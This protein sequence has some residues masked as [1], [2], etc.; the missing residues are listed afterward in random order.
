MKTLLFPS[1]IAALFSMTALLGAEIPD[2]S[3][4]TITPPVDSSK[5]PEGLSDSDWSTIRAAYEHGRHAIVANPDG[6]HQARNPGQ[7]WLTKFDEV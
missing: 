1:L 3:G 2:S 6:S 4:T 5:P 7:A